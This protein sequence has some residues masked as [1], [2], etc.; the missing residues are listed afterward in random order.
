MVTAPSSYS[1]KGASASCLSMQSHMLSITSDE[2]NSFAANLAKAYIK[3]NNLGQV[4]IWLGLF[5]AHSRGKFQWADGS[6]LGSYS[7][8]APGEPNNA[9]N[10]E[11]CSNMMAYG[12][13]FRYK[14]WNDVR[15]DTTSYKPITVCER[16]M[17]KGA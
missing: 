17:R 11:K 9:G 10:I 7:N 13:V 12:S 3:K 6:P 16:A 8:W 5:K 15:C 1:W 2:E 14:M 4:Q